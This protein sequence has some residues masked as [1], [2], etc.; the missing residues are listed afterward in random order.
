MMKIWPH[1]MTTHTVLLHCHKGSV[2][3]MLG[4]GAK[5][6]LIFGYNGD[7]KSVSSSSNTGE[8]DKESWSMRRADFPAIDG[9]STRA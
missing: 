2:M 7:G 1:M 3:T 9:Q 8:S 5:G 4:K 6:P